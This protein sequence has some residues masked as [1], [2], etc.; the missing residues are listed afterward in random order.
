MGVIRRTPRIT[1]L[2]P[3]SQI[4]YHPV[5]DRFSAVWSKLVILGSPRSGVNQG[6]TC[7]LDE[8]HYGRRAILRAILPRPKAQS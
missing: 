4:V 5:L 8:H 2:L 3:F 1:T 6:V 7:C